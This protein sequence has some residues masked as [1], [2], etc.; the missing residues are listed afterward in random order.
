MPRGSLFRLIHRSTSSSLNAMRRH[1]IAMDIA[2]GMHYLHSCRPAIVHRDLKSPNLLVDRDWTV[3]VC[4]FGLSRAKPQTYLTSRSHGGTPEWMAPEILRNE[5]SDEKCDVYSYG[6]VLYELI[7]SK[8]PWSALN[9]MQVVGAVGFA[10]Q[11]LQLPEGVAPPLAALV[12]QC[13]STKPS[14]RPSFEQVL[15]QLRKIREIV[16][17]SPPPS[18]RAE[19]GRGGDF[20]T[21]PPIEEGPIG[22]G[23]GGGE[24]AAAAAAAGA[25]AADGEAAAPA[26]AAAADAGAEA[27]PA[28]APVAA[29]PSGE[30][31][32]AVVVGAADAP[33]ADDAAAAATPTSPPAAVPV[34]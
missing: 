2:R 12:N 18:P 28:P 14:E 16:P 10:G 31:A 30:E 33:P 8:E 24:E 3:K 22:G 17:V 27:A 34:A 25:A 21:Q 23:G 15:V 20:A 1:A 7:T 19:G 29:A 26:A 6:V 5:P 9:Q 32:A 11:R 13:W 4:D